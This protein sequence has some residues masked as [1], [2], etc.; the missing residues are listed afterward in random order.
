MQTTYRLPMLFALL[1]GTAGQV[2]AADIYAERRER[3]VETAIIGQGISDERVIAVMGKVPRHEFMP[4]DQREQAYFDM[5]LPIGEGQTIS[6]PFVVA[7]MTEHL[8]PKPT[9]KVLEI[10]TGSGYQAAVLSGLVKD[11]YT[12]EIQK[13][14]G[15]IAEQRLRRLGYKNVHT[16]IGDGY[17]GWPEAAPFDKIIVTCS[18]EKIPQP[19]IDQLADGGRMMIPVGQRFQQ[20]LYL[21]TKKGDKLEKEAVEAT[22]FVPMTGTAET[23][24]EVEYDAAHPELVNGS[25]EE[26]TIIEGV[27]DGWYYARKCELRKLRDAPD[28]D[29][30]L[31]CSNTEPGKFSQILQGFGVDGQK[32]R[33]LDVRLWARAME[34][35]PPL[36]QP[37]RG[38]RLVI[39]FYDKN[40]AEV[41][42]DS[43]GPF[44]GTFGW[45]E[46][47]KSMNV[48]PRARLAVLY[49][50]L[51]GSTGELSFDKVS[52]KAIENA[53]Y[54]PVEDASIKAAEGK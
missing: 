30:V 38:P 11:V 14:L 20:V 10:G 22:M 44:T 48:P 47:H 13:P 52:V 36:G 7:S 1:V 4:R 2:R 32:V 41:G 34:V 35:L 23:L 9:D 17:K 27:P 51:L 21:Y 45:T 29:Q 8:E 16:R 50:G 46:K 26:S 24:R 28:G 37:N 54:K 39:T 53:R 31:I 12:I 6:P 33:Q 5:A 43:I 25:F 3:M 19:L 15:V 42:T 49:L 40:R 18:P